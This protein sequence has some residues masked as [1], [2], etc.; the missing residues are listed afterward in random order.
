MA[1][2]AVHQYAD[3]GIGVLDKLCYHTP[4]VLTEHAGEG[5]TLGKTYE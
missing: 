2:P 3:A 4:V 1:V 5:N